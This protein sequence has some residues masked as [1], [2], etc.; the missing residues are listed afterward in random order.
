MQISIFTNTNIKINSKED[1]QKLAK[2][3]SSPNIPVIKTITT[4]DD[5]LEIVTTYAW[6]P[7]IFEGVRNRENFVRTDWM[8]LDIDD[9]MSIKEAETQIHLMDV[10]AMVVPT[11]SHTEELNKFRV[12]FPLARSIY[13]EEEYAQTWEFLQKTFPSIDTNC[14]DTARW[15]VASTTVDG[16][17]NE[18]SKLLEPVFVANKKDMLREKLSKMGELVDV[19]EGTKKIVKQIYGEDKTKISRVVSYFIENAHTGLPGEWICSLNSF[20][21]L[22]AIQ[23]IHDNIIWDLCEQLSPEPLDKRDNQT[24]ERALKDGYEQRGKNEQKLSV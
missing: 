15:Y 12:I 9:G 1:K 8:V 19:S 7:F 10:C 14:R 20:S 13:K 6:S 16:F 5:L 22:L 2:L 11:V 17:W 23:G 21:F 24:I 18:G 4:E 3:A